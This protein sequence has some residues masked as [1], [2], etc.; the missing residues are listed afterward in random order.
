MV[1][2]LGLIFSTGERE[3]ERE[4]TEKKLTDGLYSRF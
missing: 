2:A 3:R 1:K 4:T